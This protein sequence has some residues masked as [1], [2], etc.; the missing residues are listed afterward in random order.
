MIGI[1]DINVTAIGIVV[2]ILALIIH[3]I[4]VKNMSANQIKA[5]IFMV[6]V[7]PHSEFW[8]E[9]ARIRR[10]DTKPSTARMTV[11]FKLQGLRN[12]KPSLFL[13]TKAATRREWHGNSFH[14]QTTPTYKVC[15]GVYRVTCG[16]IGFRV[17]WCYMGSLGIFQV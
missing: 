4:M 11:D 7:T 16:F 12:P 17:L 13:N 2:T 5:I 8:M 1:V 15:M 3:A 10:N 14:S 6:S 9:G